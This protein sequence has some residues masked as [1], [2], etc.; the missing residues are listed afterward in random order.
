MIQ[1]VNINVLLTRQPRQV[2]RTVTA[3]QVGEAAEVRLK[4][5]VHTSGR[6]GGV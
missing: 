5:L 6:I 3:V 2:E 4:K 1:G